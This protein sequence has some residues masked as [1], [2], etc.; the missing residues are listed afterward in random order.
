MRL[1][2]V[3]HLPVL[4]EDADGAITGSYEEAVRAGANARNIVALE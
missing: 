3:H 1:E 4:A 2:F